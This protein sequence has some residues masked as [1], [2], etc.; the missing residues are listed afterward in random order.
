MEFTVGKLT[1]VASWATDA[2]SGRPTPDSQ[3]RR[4][5]QRVVHWPDGEWHER[6]WAGVSR[7]D[8][9]SQ[10]V[11][12]AGAAKVHAGKGGADSLPGVDLAWRRSP[13]Q[14]HQ[15]GDR[16]SGAEGGG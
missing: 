10:E 14:D 8:A 5:G 1:Y 15:P 12:R 9:Q 11:L 2:L 16:R 13:A 7:R 4:A 6:P 3:K